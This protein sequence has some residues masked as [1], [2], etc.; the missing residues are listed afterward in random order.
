MSLQ[1]IKTLHGDFAAALRRLREA[2]NED[3]GKGSI[4]VDGTIQRFEFTFELAWKLAQA[5]LRHEGIEANAPRS[6]VKEA[7]KLKLIRAGDSWIDLLEDRNRTSHIY[8][9]QQSLQVYGRIKE[10]HVRLFEELGIAVE[11]FIREAG[12]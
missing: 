5:V 1:R 12:S 7:F 9:E 2:V 6:V 10:H 11:Q 8:D 3:I 4:V